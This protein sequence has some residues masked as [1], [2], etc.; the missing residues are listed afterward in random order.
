MVEKLKEQVTRLVEGP[1][2]RDGFELAHVALAAYRSRWTLRLFVYSE[3]GVSIDDCMHASAL[4]GDLIDGEDLFEH[5][6]TLEVSSPGLDRPLKTAMDFKYRVGETVRIGF[7][8]PT[9]KQVTAKIT[10][11]S[12]TVV[13]FED[14]NG[15]FTV[16]LAEIESA[17]IV[18]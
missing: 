4:V 16:G 14:Q 3:G 9:R 8:D 15:G 5:G 2:L 17:K 18:F 12:E 7:V 13:E 6:Y 1:L 11:T 10:S